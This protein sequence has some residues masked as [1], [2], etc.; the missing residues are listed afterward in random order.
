M[1][2]QTTHAQ[3]AN[4]W[5]QCDPRSLRE[6]AALIFNPHAGQKLGLETNAGSAEDVQAALR[7]EGIPFDPWPT[8]HAGH[9]T[10]LARQA[11]AEGR[12]LVIAAGGD[13]TVNEVAQGLADTP[14]V[15]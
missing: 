4:R 7:A 13:G 3:R 15:L 10:E 1:P 5:G 11:V 6:P 12:Q 2:A 8:Q 14:T 9:A